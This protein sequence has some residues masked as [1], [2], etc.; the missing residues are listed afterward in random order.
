[1]ISVRMH[2]HSF[3]HLQKKIM[4]LLLNRILVILFAVKKIIDICQVSFGLCEYSR[5]V[6]KNKFVEKKKRFPAFS[7]FLKGKAI[8][9]DLNFFLSVCKGRPR[10]LDD[11]LFSCLYIFV[12]NS[13]FSSR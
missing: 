5:F 3:V 8:L 2:A 11:Q 7:Y 1:M 13:I 6:E 12:F 4:W 10:L 9:F